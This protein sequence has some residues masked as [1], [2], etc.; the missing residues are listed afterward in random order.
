M[1]LPTHFHEHDLE[2]IRRA[3]HRGRASVFVGAGFSLNARPRSPSSRP[4]PLWR[5]L[6]EGLA[7]ELYPADAS[8]RDDIVKSA[9]TSSGALRLAELFE[10]AFGKNRLK[11]LLRRM[12]PDD[13]HDP[14]PVHRQLLELP[15]ADV[16]TTNYDTLLERQARGLL[17]RKYDVVH[18][19]SELPLASRP[20]IVKLHGTLPELRDMILTEEDYRAYPERH[21]PLVHEIRVAM[22][23]TTLCLIGFAGDDPNF[24]NWTG[25]VRDQMGESRPF[26]YFFTS[27]T[28]A[29]FQR[30]LLEDR[31]II[32]IPILEVTGE[33]GHQQALS[34]LLIHLSSPPS[35]TRY[36]H[37]GMPSQIAAT[38]KA[39]NEPKAPQSATRGDWLCV[40]IAWRAHRQSYLGWCV[41]PR[42][43]LESIWHVTEQWLIPVPVLTI[44]IFDAPTAIFVLREIVW[45][46]QTAM[47]PLWDQLVFEGIDPVLSAFAEWKTTQRD[48]DESWARLNR[49]GIS[50]NDEATSVKFSFA[51]LLDAEMQLRLETLRHAREIGNATRFQQIATAIEAQLGPVDAMEQSLSGKKDEAR[52]FVTHQCCL[53]SLSRLQHGTIRQELLTWDVDGV[54]DIWSIRKAALLLEA[55]ELE[56]ARTLLEA[57]L[58]RLRTNRTLHDTD[59]Q[60]LSREGWTVYLL[61]SL[62]TRDR[63]DK[64]YHSRTQPAADRMDQEA[65]NTTSSW[66]E[67]LNQLRDVDCDPR[68]VIDWIQLENAIPYVQPRPTT[69][70]HAFDPRRFDRNIQFGGSGYSERA[71][72]AYRAIRM[73]E[74]GAL[75]LRIG[76]LVIAEKLYRQATEFLVAA[77]PT[78][79]TG[80]VLRSRDPK[81]IES[82]FTRPRMALYSEDHVRSL[83]QL[84]WKAFHD[85]LDE[86]PLT[87]G[88][89]AFDE[90]LPVGLF[91]SAIEL[92]SRVAI[93]LS[94]SEL[95]QMLPEILALPSH[96]KLRTRWQLADCI[97]VLGRRVCTT[98]SDQAHDR[99]LLA[100][101]QTPLPGTAGLPMPINPS[102]WFDPVESLRGWHAKTLVT[103]P[104]AE[105]AIA[106]IIE[107]VARAPNSDA[108]RYAIVRLISARQA[109]LL[110]DDQANTL[111]SVLFSA[112]D[113]EF[114]FPKDTGCFDIVILVLPKVPGRNEADMFRRKYVRDSTLPN[115][116]DSD[117]AIIN[118]TDRSVGSNGTIIR[119]G[120][121]W[122]ARDLTVFVE[123]AAQ[124]FGKVG[125]ELEQH[126]A[127]P[128]PFAGGFGLDGA[129]ERQTVRQAR[130][131]LARIVLE[132]P[133]ATAKLAARVREVVDAARSQMLPVLS[134]YPALLR[135]FPELD[136]YLVCHIRQ[137]LFAD[138][139]DDR[140]DAL[141]AISCWGELQRTTAIPRIPEDILVSL[142]TLTAACQTNGL[143]HLLE[144]A[145]TLVSNLNEVEQ[146]RFAPILCHGLERLL[147]LLPYTLERNVFAPEEIPD[148]RAGCANLAGQLRNSGVTHSAIERWITIAT[149]DPL[150][151]VRKALLTVADDE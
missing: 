19:V 20:R 71:L 39:V 90:E 36:P 10:V 54:D 5:E 89:L 118:R 106:T 135:W 85:A 80:A 74:D 140:R 70:Q 3:L 42:R 143:D 86:I 50:L 146:S 11:E 30:R 144:V 47:L 45:R 77:A 26:I 43:G 69:V 84:A 57:T 128:S 72:S 28:L 27:T 103:S 35:G 56:A 1:D 7:Q 110:A 9:G 40:A 125:S 48:N 131:V 16:F 95:E 147:D 6:T 137:Q 104:E 92:L 123:N 134:V 4:F 76:N 138:D 112:V 115:L 15:W 49:D 14:G 142:A 73:I 51:E 31:R 97:A 52:Q 66:Q 25:W 101:L 111:A 32:P 44:A 120:I 17:Q 100:F 12:L 62:D 126:R 98:L 141:R 149:T 91:K 114:G 108:R 139:E 67:R 127:N 99:H 63:F 122:T 83:Q 55:R 116:P 21:A 107:N 82:F 79:A 46:F 119:R 81:Q 38:Q 41:L 22:I 88:S 133:K 132:S 65:T 109:G 24:L 102:Q 60:Q 37:W 29:P 105:E 75:P 150:P 145:S 78:E 129:S 117:F 148:L 34:K 2:L 53:Q 18:S 136:Q 8:L 130:D 113:D 59:Y 96:P 64:E 93:R 61:R 94:D 58:T 124:Y 87:P 151:E 13:D 23:E 121:R 68:D 33:T